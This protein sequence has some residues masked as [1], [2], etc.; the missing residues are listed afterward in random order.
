MLVVEKADEMAVLLVRL[1]VES[2]VVDLVVYLADQWE[3]TMAARL[4]EHS[5]ALMDALWVVQ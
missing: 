1:M 5:V 2:M 4:V 3:A